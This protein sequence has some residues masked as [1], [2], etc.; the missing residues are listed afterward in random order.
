MVSEAT[1]AW[2]MGDGP[3][4]WVVGPPAYGKHMLRLWVVGPPAYGKHDGEPF[5]WCTGGRVKLTQSS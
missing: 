5:A 4:L 3:R 2:D 1:F